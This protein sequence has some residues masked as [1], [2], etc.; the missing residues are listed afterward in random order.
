M[1]GP[2][3]VGAKEPIRFTRSY[4]ITV[5]GRV[6]KVTQREY[7][8]VQGLNKQMEAARARLEEYVAHLQARKKPRRIAQEGRST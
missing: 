3:R 4:Q 8:R 2:G 1:S 5:N 6:T 7:E